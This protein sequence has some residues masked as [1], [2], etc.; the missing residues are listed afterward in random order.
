[1]YQFI[2]NGFVFTFNTI[3]YVLFASFTDGIN[4]K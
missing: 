3:L 1:M 2:G 4:V